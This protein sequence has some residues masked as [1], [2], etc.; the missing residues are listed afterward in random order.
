MRCLLIEAD[1]PARSRT[2]RF[3]KQEGF[4]VDIG[5]AAEDALYLAATHS[6]ACL[7]LDLPVIGTDPS[8]FL[9]RLTCMRPKTP[10]IVISEKIPV[11]EIVMKLGA[12]ADDHL[13]RPFASAELVARMRVLIRRRHGHESNIITTDDLVIDTSLKTVMRGGAE[14]TLTRREYNLL[15]YLAYRSGESV[16]RPEI[17]NHVFDDQSEESGN[18][19]DVY[20]GYLRKKL[21][22]N[23][24]PDLI[25]TVR[26]HG[27]LLGHRLAF[28][29]NPGIRSG[30]GRA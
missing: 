11:G 5:G 13:T 17:R 29:G 6:Y 3:L 12:G 21:N 8:G 7:L 24:A 30:D 22:V 20:V 18:S 26:G 4:V 14:I 19:V 10:M 27:Y 25:Q 1:T 28:Q 2:L 16:S 9:Q 23:G 15:E